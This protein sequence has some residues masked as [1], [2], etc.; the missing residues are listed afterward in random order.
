MK[1]ISVAARVPYEAKGHF[2]VSTMR[3][4]GKAETGAEKFWLGFSTFLPGGGADYSGEDSPTEKVYYVLTGE[5]TV[6]DKEG[7]A[8]VVHANEAI[9]FAPHEGRSLK[10]ETNEPATMLVIVNY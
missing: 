6:R 1:K 3:I 2:G 10:N 8:Y 5:M 4:H 7:N 9:C